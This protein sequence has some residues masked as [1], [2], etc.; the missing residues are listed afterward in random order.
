MPQWTVG[1]RVH[2]ATPLDSTPGLE[3]GLPLLMGEI[4][5]AC[6]RPESMLSQLEQGRLGGYPLKQ[7]IV[8]LV[9]YIS[10]S[11]QQ[12]GFQVTEEPIYPLYAGTL[13]PDMVAFKN[14]TALVLDA[15]VVG[16]SV[17]LD[18]AHTPKTIKYTQ[19]ER[20]VKVQPGTKKVEFSPL[21][22]IGKASGH[23]HRLKS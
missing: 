19:L 14:K 10:R 5:L 16:A 18:S 21:P 22:S 11:L 4:S 9:N 13:K 12:K 7:E 23:Q 6:L 1:R 8:G 3:M 15:Q 2:H 17:E 20:E